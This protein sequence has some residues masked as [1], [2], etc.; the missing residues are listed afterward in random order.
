MLFTLKDVLPP[1]VTLCNITTVEFVDNVKFLGCIADQGL[2]WREHVNSVCKKVAMGVAMLRSVWYYPFSIKKMIYFGYVLPHVNYCLAAWGGAADIHVNKVLLLQKA[3]LRI[4]C[5]L[6]SR[7]HVQPPDGIL[8]FH[9]LYKMSLALY[10]YRNFVCKCN[11]SLFEVGCYVNQS[12]VK[13]KSTR[14]QS[15]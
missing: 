4:M 11:V 14:G 15:V 8:L 1:V 6:P 5:G 13:R 7:A 9:D 2:T 10:A 3:A 12:H